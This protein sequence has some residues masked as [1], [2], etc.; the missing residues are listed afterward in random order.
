MMWNMWAQDAHPG[1]PQVVV[2]VSTWL[3]LRHRLH[4]PLWLVLGTCRGSTTA[5]ERGMLVGWVDRVAL[6]AQG[7]CS[8]RVTKRIAV[9]GAC[10]VQLHFDANHPWRL[11]PHLVFHSFIHSFYR[12]CVLCAKLC[13][14]TKDRD[15]NKIQSNISQKSHL[16][17]R[18][19]VQ[20]RGQYVNQ[21]QGILM[22]LS[23]NKLRLWINIYEKK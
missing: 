19:V 17:I 6:K 3:G 18:I 15:M 1:K 21:S 22:P 9:N 23:I 16:W 5:F 20:S 12:E 4:Q 8:Q 2:G 14:R 13:A 10:F 11:L 7:C